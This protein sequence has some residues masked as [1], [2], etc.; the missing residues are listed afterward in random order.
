MKKFGILAL[1]LMLGVGAAF[2]SSISVPWF[3]DYAE[4]A[5]GFPPDEGITTL[6]Y[7]KSNV[8]EQMELAIEYYNAN[9]EALGSVN[10]DPDM[11]GINTFYI[12]PQSAL[13]FRP[14]R[15]DP[16]PNT[17]DPRTGDAGAN[18]G[19]EGDQ[20]VLVPVRPE[21]GSGNL[22]NG[23]IT[24]SWVGEPTDVQGMVVFAGETLSYAHLLPPGN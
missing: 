12:A 7:L 10:P 24:I 2:S 15:I 17:T 20:G 1:V 18:G 5:S 11:E 3:L 4:E 21:T 23:S 8:D 6:V 19:Q 16:A 13:A 9:G 14:V 22:F